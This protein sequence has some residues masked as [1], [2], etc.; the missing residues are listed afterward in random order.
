MALSRRDVFKVAGLGLV[1]SSMQAKSTEKKQILKQ[2]P[3]IPHVVVVGGGVGG[4]VFAK[5]LAIKNK[6]IEI[7]LLEKREVFHS[8]PYSNLYLGEVENV[9]LKD[10]T[11][12]YY[13]PAAK[14]GYD[15]ICC[16]VTDI[17]RKTK[18]VF[19]SKGEIKYDLLVLSPGIDYNY[20]EQF[21]NLSEKKAR[22][23]LIK[24]TPAMIGTSEHFA[25]KRKLD[26]FKSGNIV[27]TVPEGKYR[28]PPA[29]YERA[30]MI[31]NLIKKKNLKAK[32]IILDYT[33]KPRAKSDAF[34]EAFNDLYSDIITFIGEAEIENINLDNQTIKYRTYKNYEDY[35]GTAKTINYEILN[36]IPIQ[37]ASNV[38]KMADLQTDSWGGALMNGA[39]YK[40]KSDNDVYVLGD[41]TSYTFPPSA[42]MA[43]STAKICA[44]FIN[45]R[46]RGEKE[47]L[48]LP[49]NVC[50]S[51]VGE[52]P[53]EAIAVGHEISYDKTGMHVKAFMN[54]TNGKYRSRELAQG[55]HEWYKNLINE[56]FE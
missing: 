13:K 26:N 52:N 45:S 24:T 54:K 33:K 48:E 46:L 37:K 36:L 27:I 16:E 56:M 40:S 15:F 42:Q 9:K 25:L 39:T 38:I 17:N 35:E 19:T 32:V 1:A 7:T 6:N 10:L 41:C 34:L 21:P 4:L 55:A 51:L 8:C 14:Y 2:K 20:K 28:C 29:P 30:C 3:K 49:G 5:N 50:Y 44:N 18:I 22:E 53:Q 11:H 23:F 12:D 31:A 43:T 47:I